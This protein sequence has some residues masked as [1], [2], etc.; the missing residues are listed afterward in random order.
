MAKLF[1]NSRDP[2]QMPCSAASDLGL[3][4]VCQL[5]FY[6][7]PVYNWLRVM[8]VVLSFHDKMVYTDRLQIRLQ[9]LH[10]LPFHNFRFVCV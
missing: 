7:F 3:Q 9:G 6:G 2:D 8:V 5:P 4:S 10:C 1:V